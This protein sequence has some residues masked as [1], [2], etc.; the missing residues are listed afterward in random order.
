MADVRKEIRK[1][2]KETHLERRAVKTPHLVEIVKRGGSW[3]ALWDVALHLGSRHTAGLQHLMRILAH[4]GHWLKPCPM[5]DECLMRRSLIDHIL[6]THGKEL[7]LPVLT[8]QPTH[9]QPRHNNYKRVREHAHLI[10]VH[11]HY[12]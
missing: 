11:V 4:H 5:C 7:E 8:L 9:I 1:R 10:H 3:P 2:D 12:S 6:D